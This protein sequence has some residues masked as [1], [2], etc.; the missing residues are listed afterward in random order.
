M[1]GG[2]GGIGEEEGE[3]GRRR[4]KKR[5]GKRGG[6]GGRGE[7]E[8]EEGRRSGKRGGVGI[9]VRYDGEDVM[10]EVYLESI[11]T[12]FLTWEEWK[13]SLLFPIV[14]VKFVSS[15]ALLA[16]YMAVMVRGPASRLVA[17]T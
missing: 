2:G 15:T 12:K 1:R 17:E 16:P 7:E 3:E 11:P 5:R 14:R 13:R 8:W 10:W 6:G 4:G 9:Q